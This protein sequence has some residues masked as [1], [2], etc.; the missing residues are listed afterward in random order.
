VNLRRPSGT[1]RKD[2]AGAAFRRTPSEAP[3]YAPMRAIMNRDNVLPEKFEHILGFFRALDCII[4][5]LFP[6][7]EHV[8]NFP[9]KQPDSAEW[10]FAAA[11]DGFRMFSAQ[12]ALPRFGKTREGSV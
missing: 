2:A 6:E 8:P 5:T 12:F 7:N 11:F 4:G 1:D 3:E 10:L 9:T